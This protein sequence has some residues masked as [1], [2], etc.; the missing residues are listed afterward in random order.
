M[1]HFPLRFNVDELFFMFGVI[2]NVISIV[3]AFYFGHIIA[4]ILLTLCELVLLSLGVL[5][6]V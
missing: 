2:M 6:L 4:G 5:R 3:F 1:R